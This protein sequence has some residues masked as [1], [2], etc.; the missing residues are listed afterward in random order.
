MAHYF[1]DWYNPISAIERGYGK[2]SGNDPGQNQG[3]LL[4]SIWNKIFGGGNN[5]QTSDMMNQEGQ[6][7][8]T[9]SPLGISGDAAYNQTARAYQK[10][11]NDMLV[12]TTIPTI[13]R[14]FS[15]R[16]NSGQRN[17][18][19]QTATNQSQSTV[20]TVLGQLALQKYMQELG[21]EEERWWRQAQ[22]D[23]ADRP[24]YEDIGE[25]VGKVLP[26]LILL[27]AGG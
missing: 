17:K 12:Q 13:N 26:Y 7:I 9:K 22:L 11:A 1:R 10:L 27:T 16:Y 14:E 5:D 25:N 19:I 24:W 15:N 4:S 2:L 18:A 3:I 6:A 23:V 21:L 8:S 20:N